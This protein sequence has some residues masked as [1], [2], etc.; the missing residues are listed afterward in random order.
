MARL[1]TF[2][3]SFRVKRSS[4]VAAS[5]KRTVRSPD[6][7]TRVAPSG[8]YA[9]AVTAPAWPCN[10]FIGAAEELDQ[11]V[12]VLSSDP[13]ARVSLPGCSASARIGKAV[14]PFK[15]AKSL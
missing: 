2:P 15:V 5:Q 10:C 12:T 4:P 9:K 13:E 3:G 14:P 6:P 1:R 11:M 7:D 8:E